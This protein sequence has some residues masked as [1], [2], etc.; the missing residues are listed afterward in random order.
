MKNKFKKLT[1]IN[2]VLF[3]LGSLLLMMYIYLC[4][5]YNLQFYTEDER[6]L[7]WDMTNLTSLYQWNMTNY[8]I[9]SSF[10]NYLYYPLKYILDMGSS[11]L[12]L[13]II[14]MMLSKLVHSLMVFAGW[15]W[16]IVEAGKILNKRWGLSPF[17]SIL[18]FIF[19]AMLPMNIFLVKT[20][21]YDSIYNILCLI[22]ILYFFRYVKSYSL[23]E[24]GFSFLLFALAMQEKFAAYPV[25]IVFF[26]LVPFWVTEEKFSDHFKLVAAVLSGVIAGS[27]LP[28]FLRLVSELLWAQDSSIISVHLSQYKPF[29]TFSTPLGTAKHFIGIGSDFFVWIMAHS[30]FVHMA[31]FLIWYGAIILIKR[32]ID[33]SWV[34][35]NKN[36]WVILAGAVQLLFLLWAFASIWYPI[37]ESGIF[38]FDTPPEGTYL[39]PHLSD[40]HPTFYYGTSHFGYILIRMMQTIGFFKS[41]L[42]SPVLLFLIMGPVCTFLSIRK[43]DLR[44]KSMAATSVLIFNL[45]MALVILVNATGV[46]FGGRY[47][48]IYLTLLGLS[49][50]FNFLFVLL[51]FVGI[52]TVNKNKMLPAAIFV[53][54]IICMAELL[55]YGPSYQVF[56]NWFYPTSGCGGWGEPTSALVQASRKDAFLKQAIG[57][58]YT[59]YTGL[60]I[61]KPF[62]TPLINLR[63][64][65]SQSGKNFGK[66]RAI[67]YLLAEGTAIAQNPWLKK[68]LGKAQEIDGAVVWKWACRGEASAWLIDLYKLGLNDFQDRLDVDKVERHYLGEWFF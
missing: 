43:K 9:S 20:N 4:F 60:A 6:Y 32:K 45:T 25:F 2:P 65:Q 14:P 61:E 55:P 58:T 35:K 39:P 64:V 56:G 40:S 54:M 10:G 15:I 36:V 3:L 23:R 67:Q 22:G 31:G 17:T 27:L 19:T 30:F 29:V 8:R 24:I 49:A 12:G 51:F 50:F 42:Y 62:F 1:S 7:Q 37:P 53:L 46:P 26:V 59:T 33:F 41:M 57:R 48:N 18:C 34:G 38:P 68:V 21:N 16:F 52:E 44:L 5:A 66:R 63:L 47:A 11:A 13:K 28:S